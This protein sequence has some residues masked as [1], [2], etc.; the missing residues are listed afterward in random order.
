MKW[1]CKQVQ[2]KRLRHE[3]ISHHC[4]PTNEVC[5]S[6]ISWRQ[7]RLRLTHKIHTCACSMAFGFAARMSENGSWLNKNVESLFMTGGWRIAVH[8]RIC[9]YFRIQRVQSKRRQKL[10]DGLKPSLKSKAASSCNQ[11]DFEVL[12]LLYAT[13]RAPVK[14]DSIRWLHSLRCPRI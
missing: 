12:I 2:Y 14:W 7:M 10:K 13:G 8:G 3:S 11:Q 5:Q 4:W 9:I 1:N 6:L